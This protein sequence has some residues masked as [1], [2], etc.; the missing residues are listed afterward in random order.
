MVQPQQRRT[1]HFQLESAACP[2]GVKCRL[3]YAGMSARRHAEQ[4]HPGV[5]IPRKRDRPTAEVQSMEIQ[6]LT[7]IAPI[8]RDIEGDGLDR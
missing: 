1:S 8:A 3:D 7:S 5:L 2:G 6:F 4:S